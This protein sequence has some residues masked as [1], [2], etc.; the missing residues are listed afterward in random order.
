MQI[1]GL[2][3]L[4]VPITQAL[5][6]G[7]TVS[8][9]LLGIGL[10]FNTQMQNISNSVDNISSSVDSVE[11]DLRQVDL[12]ELEKSVYRLDFQIGDE[13]EGPHSVHH[14]LK[15]SEIG[16][17]VSLAAGANDATG[18]PGIPLKDIDDAIEKI[19]KVNFES[20]EELSEEELIDNLKDVDFPLTVQADVD[21]DEYVMV[22]ME[23]E[24]RIRSKAVSERLKQDVELEQEELDLFGMECAFNATSPFEIVFSVPSTDFE[25]VAEWTPT[26]LVRID[27]YHVDFDKR[28]KEFDKALEE[29]L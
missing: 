24:E 5:V 21:D 2:V 11:N 20:K 15:R 10:K 28:S 16:V 4:V 23:F 6:V 19:D 3:D 25:E 12:K 7:A 9:A 13:T 8:L 29:A 26:I 18:P 17:T 14:T 27:R 1:F 22:I